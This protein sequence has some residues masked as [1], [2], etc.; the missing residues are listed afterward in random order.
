MPPVDYAKQYRV[1]PF[2]KS[3][4]PDY[5]ERMQG[6]VREAAA[7]WDVEQ[8]FAFLTDADEEYDRRVTDSGGIPRLGSL[9]YQ[10]YSDRGSVLEPTEK[11]LALLALARDGLGRCKIEQSDEQSEEESRR[12]FAEDDEVGR[13]RNLEYRR[14]ELHSPHYVRPE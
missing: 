11:M 2:L 10:K 13:L 5:D 6:L 7:F 14:R 3:D 1:D 4:D 12:I 8:L 9:E